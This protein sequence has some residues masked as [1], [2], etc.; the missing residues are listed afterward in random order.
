MS[1]KNYR[2]ESLRDKIEAKAVEAPKAK[3][4][5]EVRKTKK[6]KK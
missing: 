6:G 1:L 4:V 3:A 2:R 5:V